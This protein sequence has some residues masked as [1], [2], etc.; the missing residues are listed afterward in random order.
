MKVSLEWIRDYVDLPAGLGPAEL[1]QEL[2]LK[3]V[4]VEAAV[5]AGR[6]V[7]LEIDNKSL[8][9][10][11]DLWGHYGMAR[12]A[13]AIYGLP[14]RPLP[15]PRR[16]EQMSGLIG[17]VQPSLCSRFAAIEF[18]GDGPAATPAWMRDRLA[19]IG[20]AS[21]NPLVDLS[22][23]VMFTVGQPS[24]V[25]DADRVMLPL[26][27][28][29]AEGRERLE[30]LTGQSVDLAGGVPVIR[31]ARE[32]V[33]LAGI[34]GGAES[35]VT[36]KS[37]HFVLEAATFRARSIRRAAQQLGLRTEASVRFEKGIDTQRV[38]AALG[39]FLH[40][41]PQVAPNAAVAGMQDV[42]MEPTVSAQIALSREFLDRRIGESLPAAE[43][44]GTLAALGFAVS[45]DGEEMQVTAPSWRS[46]GDVSLP[47]DI[48]EEVA[49]VHGFDRLAVAQTPVTLRPARALHRRPLDRDVREQLA[50]RAGLHEVV[51]YPWTADHLLAAAGWAKTDT[52]RFEGAPA[53]DRDSLRPSLIPNLLEAVAAN[54]RYFPAFGLFEVGTV[55]GGG[56]LV[57]YRGMYEPIPPL[58][59]ALGVALAGTDGTELFRSAK[60]VVEML[61]RRCYIAGLS[62]EGD[63]DMPWADRSARLAVRTGTDQ[64]GAIGL[65]TPRTRR[66]AGIDGVQ[67]AC[68]EIDLA[69]LTRH[70]SRENRF[71]PLP[72]LPETDFDLSVVA[73]DDISW[74]RVEQT[75]KAADQLIAG[76]SYVSEYRGSWVPE[77]HRSLTLRVTLRPTETTL[78]AEVIGEARSNVLGVLDRELNARLR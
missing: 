54:L 67:V 64:A 26:S 32:T 10:R 2:T 43:I 37:R 9:N 78:T 57:P 5:P 71:Q 70:H 28:G 69:R 77:G 3:T 61:R 56:D 50:T 41:L 27:A 24:H 33:G 76:V 15:S 38:D 45:A 35:A 8:T 4:E 44:S 47:H 20:E 25:Y 40:L 30:L 16:P 39:L 11:P 68:V 34:M 75:V 52:V 6:D 53:P 29:T 49:R 23:Y 59:T 1:A 21:R 12:E 72:E 14:L 65:V 19:R 31:D 36:A 48:V 63:T 60:G 51:T 66:L 46:T 62:L 73:A 13:A 58:T 18:T 17:S 7:I 22:N 42:T 74:A 55:F